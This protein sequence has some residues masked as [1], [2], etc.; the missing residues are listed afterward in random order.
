M[1]DINSCSL[2]SPRI[3]SAA[4][5]V[6]PA[7]HAS[8]RLPCACRHPV[9]GPLRSM[10]A[11]CSGLVAAA[12]M[13]LSP[14]AKT[15]QTLH[16]L[17]T[18]LQVTKLTPANAGVIYINLTAWQELHGDL[19]RYAELNGWIFPNADQARPWAPLHA[20]ALSVGDTSQQA[21]RDHQQA[22]HC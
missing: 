22:W 12:C 1:E 2:P 21:S 5:E 15:H 10:L 6:T 4:G 16:S 19:M 9:L 14:P 8:H 7:A 11:L 3:L 13:R 20:A 17:T 18:V